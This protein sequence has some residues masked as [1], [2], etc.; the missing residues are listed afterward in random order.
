MQ[1][2]ITSNADAIESFQSML[3]VSNLHCA[4]PQFGEH[5]IQNV[6]ISIRPEIVLRGNGKSGKKL[7]GGM[8]LYFSRTYPLSADGAG[9]VS[10]TLQEY[11]KTDLPDDEAFGHF[12]LW[13]TLVRRPSI[14]A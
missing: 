2:R 6:Q 1:R 10:A 12:A 3:D 7:V 13:P 5:A 8:K 14:R 11:C 9:I 4:A